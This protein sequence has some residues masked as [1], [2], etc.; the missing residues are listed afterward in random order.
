LRVIR[1]E[2]ETKIKKYTEKRVC[3]LKI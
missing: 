2:C 1:K 3:Y